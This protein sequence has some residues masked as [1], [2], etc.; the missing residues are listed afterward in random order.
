MGG[1]FED[2][3]PP[4]DQPYSVFERHSLFLVRVPHGVPIKTNGLV[5]AECAPIP[6]DDYLDMLINRALR[7]RSG[8]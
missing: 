8:T 3:T 1:L 4:A 7:D 2:D 5:I 6:T